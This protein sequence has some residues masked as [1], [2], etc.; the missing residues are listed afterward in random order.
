MIKR[1]PA[2]PA[3]QAIGRALGIWATVL[4][5]LTLCFVAF[6]TWSVAQRYNDILSTSI[7]DYVVITGRATV[8]LRFGWYSRNTDGYVPCSN[9]VD[10]A[11]LCSIG[12]DIL[13]RQPVLEGWP[14]T[15]RINWG[16]GSIDG[17]NYIAL[18]C[19]TI[20]IT[21]LA[22]IVWWAKRLKTAGVS[23]GAGLRDVFLTIREQGD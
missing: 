18:G 21:W 17:W 13:G 4:F 12:D 2:T 10:G 1:S 6:T 7:D 8:T 3:S 16:E 15:W 19:M 9:L 14:L 5:G 22:T 23:L 20:M 11:Q